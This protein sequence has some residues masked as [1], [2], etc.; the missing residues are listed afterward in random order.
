MTFVDPI[1][2]MIARIRNAQMRLLRNVTIPNSKFRIRILE[3]L[4]QEGYISDYKLLSDS[5]NKNSLSVDLKYSNGLPVIREIKIISKPGRRIYA[6]ADSIPKIQNGLGLAI[7]STSKGIM[8]DSDA[9]NQNVG[10][11]IICRIF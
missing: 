1:S 9:R 2:D 8:T 6:K 4:K 7:L 11:E 3:V 10:G 5:N